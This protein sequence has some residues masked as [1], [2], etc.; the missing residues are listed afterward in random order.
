MAERTPPPLPHE[1]ASQS[2]PP[3]EAKPTPLEQIQKTVADVAT[4]VKGVS[5]LV[6]FVEKHLGGTSAAKSSGFPAGMPALPGSSSMPG[7]PTQMPPLP[8]SD[9]AVADAG[10]STGGFLGF[11]MPDFNQLAGGVPG[12]SMPDMSQWT[13]GFANFPTADWGMGQ[14]FD[15]N[16]FQGMMFDPNMMN[17]MDFGQM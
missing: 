3:A 7:F 13:A 11:G 1:R 2:A 17:G 16:L 5:Q 8:G 4:C 15:P 12:F 9:F 10:Q 14:A 6:G